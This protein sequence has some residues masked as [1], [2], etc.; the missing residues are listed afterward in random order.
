MPPP[1]RRGASRRRLRAAVLGTPAGGGVPEGA[2]RPLDAV[3]GIVL[4]ASPHLLVVGTAD[5]ET[6]FAMSEATPVWHGGRGGLAALR[7]GRN[8]IVRARDTG[9]PSDAIVSDDSPPDG[10]TPDGT[11]PAGAASRPSRSVF[12]ADRVWVDICRVAGTILACRKDAVEVDM[13]PHRGRARVVIPPSALERVLVRHPRLEP[14]YLIDVICVRSSG[15]P[16]AVRPGTSQPGYRADDLAAPEIGAPVPG[17]LRGTATWFGGLHDG[18]GVDGEGAADGAAYPAV[19]S[20]GDAGGCADAPSGCVAFPYLSLGSDITVRNECGGR[21]APVP[22]VECGCVA[23]RFCDRCVDCGASP[24][25]RIVELT[26]AAFVGL[27]GDLEAG[28]FNA[29]V[30]PGAPSATPERM[31]EGAASW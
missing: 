27:G 4:D 2:K 3:S 6:R 23:A 1:Q 15:G 11:T 28:C 18:P 17:V 24:R 31:A 29:V 21:A 13:G 9:H 5:G 19:D 12:G 20:E 25:G 30:R 8:V 26:P 22:V 14:G 16:W 10:T 7:P